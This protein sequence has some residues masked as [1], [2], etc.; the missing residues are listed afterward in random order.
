MRCAAL[1]LA[2]LSGSAL[3][4]DPLPSWNEGAAKQAIL[5]FVERV[6]DEDSPDFVP[7]PERVA[8]FDNDGCLWA[9]RPVYFQALFAF[10]RVKALAAEHPEWKEQEPFASVLRGDPHPE[11]LAGYRWRD[12]FLERNPDL[13]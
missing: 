6:T 12:A 2:A 10:D 5:E 7:E 13:R 1:L 4:A 3:A 9:E 11:W 8:T